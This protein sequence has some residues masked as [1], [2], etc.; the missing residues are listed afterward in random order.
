MAGLLARSCRSAP[1]QQRGC[2]W[3]NYAETP[4]AAHFQSFE[5]NLQQREL[6]RI[7]TG[8][9]FNLVRLNYL[10]GCAVETITATKVQFFFELMSTSSLNF[11]HYSR[12]NK[13]LAGLAG[14]TINLGYIFT[15]L[16]SQQASPRQQVPVRRNS[17][18]GSSL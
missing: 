8:F 12:S 3:L 15:N 11:P 2:Q 5:R 14:N 17:M 18:P 9:P 4:I 16:K 1:S 6:L 7:C 10:S 13:D